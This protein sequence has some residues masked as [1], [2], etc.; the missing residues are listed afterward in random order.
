V[1]P[2]LTFRLLFAFVILRHDRRELVQI[3]VTDHP[4]A[5]GAARQVIDAF[6]YEL[7]PKYLLRDRDA[8]YGDEFTRPIAHMGIREVLIVCAFHLFVRSAYAAHRR[9]S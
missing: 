2:T 5:T 9:Y 3:D 4:T 8:T 7:A 1:V 6:P